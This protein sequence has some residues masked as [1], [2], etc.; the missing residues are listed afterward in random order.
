MKLTKL[1]RSTPLFKVYCI[2][3]LSDARSKTTWYG[4]IVTPSTEVMFWWFNLLQSVASW[5]NFFTTSEHMT[6]YAHIVG[7]H[8][9]KLLFGSWWRLQAPHANRSSLVLRLPAI[10]YVVGSNG[11]FSSFDQ[12]TRQN[13]CCGEDGS[14]PAYL[15]ECIQTVYPKLLRYWNRIQCLESR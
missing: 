5:Q 10:F 15:L 8:F 13:V 12:S 4:S 7:N 1:V 2:M 3:S 6:Y 11:S 14:I 9:H